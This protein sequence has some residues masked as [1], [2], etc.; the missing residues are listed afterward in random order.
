MPVEGKK[1]VLSLIKAVTCILSSR[2]VTSVS[3]EIFLLAFFIKH[4]KSELQCRV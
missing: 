1:S 4:V 3:F 2:A